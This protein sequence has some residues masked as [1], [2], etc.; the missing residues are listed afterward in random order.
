[1]PVPAYVINDMEITD[2]L[3]FEE[4]KRLSPPTVAA[5]GGRFLAR[6]GEVSPLEGDWQP[7]RLVMLEFPSMALA[8]A[9]LNSPEYAPARR[10]RQLSANSRMVVIEG[11]LPI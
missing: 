5:Y 1:M 9:W 10:L 2:P 7:K 11:V 6:G 4:Y 3:R 8:Q